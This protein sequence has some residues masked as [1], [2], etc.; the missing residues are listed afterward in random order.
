MF[1]NIESLLPQNDLVN[2]SGKLKVISIGDN[3][4]SLDELNSL[5]ETLGVVS[6]GRVFAVLRK[7]NPATY[8]GK[9]KL[10]ELSEM[11]VRLGAG[12][13]V[14]DAE[15]SPKQLANL[16]KSVGKPALDRPG[17]IIEIFSRHARTREAKNQVALAR[18]QYLMPRLAHFWTHFERQDGGSTGS[19][20]MGEKQ[21]EVD[22]RLIKRQIHILNG[23]LKNIECERKIQRTNRKGILKVALVGYTN[24]GKSTLLNALTNSNVNAEDKLFATLDA[25]VRALDPHSHPPVVAIDTVGFI[26]RLPPSL[27]ASFRS[28]LEELVESDLLVHVVDVSSPYAKQQF[29]T[30]ET[31]LKD[32]NVGAKPRMVVLN[33]ADLL[34]G[35][36]TRNWSKLICPGAMAISA[37]DKADV[38]KLRETILS[39]FRC[40]MESWEIL[41]PYSESKIESQ[42]FVYGNV[43][44]NRHMDKGTFYRVRIEER[45]ARKL[46]LE[47]FKL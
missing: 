1:D 15:L 18:L 28:T 31:I 4:Q 32:L 22:R 20:G 17:V 2:G 29:E 36:N 25:S 14:V 21:I 43:E 3:E 24:A 9:G 35:A 30:T 23:R 46:G 13:V 37:L 7:I 45:W 19:R 10:T 40:K 33:K 38:S 44:V 47:K 5:L 8:I 16:E 11:A 42:L 12:A 26:S 34:T 41:L 39:H 6:I 27:I